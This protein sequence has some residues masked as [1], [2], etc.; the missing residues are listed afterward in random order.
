MKLKHVIPATARL[1]FTL[2]E[3]ILAIGIMAIVLVAI[4]AVFFSALRLRERSV[5]TVEESLPIQQALAILRRDLQGAMAPSSNAVLAGT[6]RAGSVTSI[7]SSF[8]LSL[9]FNTTTGVLRDNEPWGEIQKV[10][11]GLR[12]SASRNVPGNDLYRSV[13]RNL[14]ATITPQPEEQWMMGG[15]QSM[16]I[17][18]Y[19]GSQW[20]SDWDTSVTDT[21]L[22]TAVRVRILLVGGGSGTSRPIEMIVPIDSQSLTNQS[23]ATT[24]TE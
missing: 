5:A 9:E 6:F 22:P 19:D 10:G 24:T 15:V 14:L 3:L 13:T 16:E 11:Y 17:S 21:N 1:A 18:C 8:P 12:S 20:R 23:T 4:N 7:G 2:I